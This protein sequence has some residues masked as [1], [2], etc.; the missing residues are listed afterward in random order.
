MDNKTKQKE[1]CWFHRHMRQNGICSL[2]SRNVKLLMWPNVFV[3]QNQF[4]SVSKI[5][6]KIKISKPDHKRITLERCFFNFLF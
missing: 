4:Q 3:N 6:L 2:E 1:S 5:L